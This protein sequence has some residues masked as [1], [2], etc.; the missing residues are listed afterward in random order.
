[1][2]PQAREDLK[3]HPSFVP[4]FRFSPSSGLTALEP[5]SRGQVVK[6]ALVHPQG[7]CSDG[8]VPA[9]L[10]DDG[11]RANPA[12]FANLATLVTAP[13]ELELAFANLQSFDLRFK[14]GWWNSK[15]DRRP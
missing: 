13:A 7:P 15:L 9:I 3:Q 12:N 5:E 4:G 8:P 1:M 2:P 6:V 11:E 10:R 14:S